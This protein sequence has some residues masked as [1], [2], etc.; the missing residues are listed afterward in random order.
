M[1]NMS[2]Y[3]RN[4]ASDNEVIVNGAKFAVSDEVATQIMSIIANAHVSTPSV[5]PTTRTQTV[6]QSTPKKSTKKAKAFAKATDFTVPY[7]VRKADKGYV[8]GFA[9]R[10]PRDAYTVIADELKADN[11][12]WNKELKGFAFKTKKLAEEFSKA[13]AVITADARE[14]VRATWHKE[15]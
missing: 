5:A 15:V 1:I 4:T 8:L 6:S 7:E 3:T 10:V 11:I 9:D 13:H 14:K 12:A 2:M